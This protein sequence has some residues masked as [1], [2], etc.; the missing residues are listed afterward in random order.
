MNDTDVTT[1]RSS[2]HLGT[3]DL[4]NKASILQFHPVSLIELWP[5]EEVEVLDLVVLSNQRCRETE[6]AV[7][8][9]RWGGRKVHREGMNER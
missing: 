6:L 2:A 9:Y 5:Y 1:T 8:L 4:G 7:C 3:L